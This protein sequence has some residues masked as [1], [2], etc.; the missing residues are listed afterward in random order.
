MTPKTGENVAQKLMEILS[1]NGLGGTNHIMELLLN[2]LMKVERNECLKAE[3]YERSEDRQGYANGFKPKTLDTRV[4]K[5]EISVPQVRGLSFYP[6]CIEK[7]SRSERALKCAVAEMYVQGVSTRRITAITKELCG[8]EISSGQVSRVAKVLDEEIDKFKARKLGQ[9]PYIIL[10][11]RYEKV[12]HKGCVRDFAVLVAV[13]VNPTGKREILGYSAALSEAE[14]HWR[15][16]LESLVAKGIHGVEFIVSD[17]HPGLANA[18]KAVFPS[19]IWQRCQF[20]FQQNVTQYVPK[21]AM[22]K[23]VA[24][25]IRNIFNAA[26]RDDAEVKKQKFINAYHDKAPALVK[27]VELTIDECLNAFSLPYQFR[28]KL[29][30]SNSLELLNR[31]IRRRTKIAAIFPNVESC[32]RLIGAVLLEIHDDWISRDE[33]YLN[34]KIKAEHDKILNQEIIYRRKVA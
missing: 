23:P 6:K 28:I 11:A 32:E 14:V 21:L 4:G 34:M 17:A 8:L 24:A 22:R 5:L 3:P 1:E 2:E 26:D 12:R 9:I 10:D 25:A 15:G 18:R 30:T 31:E 16:F 13:G 7:G 19:V 27:W 33:D 20:H 29:R